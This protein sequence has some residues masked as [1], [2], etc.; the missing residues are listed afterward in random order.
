MSRP[1]PTLVVEKLKKP[2]GAYIVAKARAEVLSEHMATWDK[3]ELDANEYTSRYVEG[4]RVTEP[5]LAW[6]IRDEQ[7]DEF[8][9]KRNDYIAEHFEVPRRGYCPALMAA[10]A[11]HEAERE[12]L[13]AAA[14][15]VPGW[16]ADSFNI[17]LTLKARAV[18]LLCGLFVESVRFI[19]L[20]KAP[21]TTPT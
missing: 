7:T 4:E 12:L 15:I 3:A 2:F 21:C 1:P 9:R 11:L 6:T 5:R 18:D 19:Q 10:T 20:E 16:K 14:G 8:Y 13:E 17:N